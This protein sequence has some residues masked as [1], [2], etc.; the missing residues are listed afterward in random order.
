MEQT[1][2]IC[3]DIIDSIRNEDSDRFVIL[4][5]QLCNNDRFGCLKWSL[6]DAR[7]IIDQASQAFIADVYK[8]TGLMLADV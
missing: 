5:T 7:Y 1:K 8:S 4:Y 3:D 6:R 2:C